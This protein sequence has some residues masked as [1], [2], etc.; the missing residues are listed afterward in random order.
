M[1]KAR[2]LATRPG[3]GPAYPGHRKSSQQLQR[4]PGSSEHTVGDRALSAS[5]EPLQRLTAHAH[6]SLGL[7]VFNQ[8]FSTFTQTKIGPLPL[9][10]F[11]IQR[12][13]CPLHGIVDV[14][15][16][17]W[18]NLPNLDRIIFFPKLHNWQSPSHI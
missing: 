4:F 14:K 2:Y 13:S 6:Q 8:P 3:M 7:H 11:K 12:N 1:Q 10:F 9:F 15:K 5:A 18:L 16:I 17:I